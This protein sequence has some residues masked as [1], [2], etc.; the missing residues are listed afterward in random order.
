MWTADTWQEITII[1]NSLSMCA[2]SDLT[3]CTS[4]KD[5]TSTHR[6]PF[7]VYKTSEVGH[8][9]LWAQS[10]MGSAMGHDNLWVVQYPCIHNSC[11]W[12]VM[13]TR[14]YQGC[15]VF[16][17][18]PP[19]SYQHYE[20]MGGVSQR[21]VFMIKLDIQ[22]IKAWAALLDMGCSCYVSVEDKRFV[23]STLPRLY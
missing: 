9:Q 3:F 14:P 22:C 19:L 11:P 2:D 5:V 15:D 8:N 13:S 18:L 10:A 1:T 21:S 6:Y 4:H 17:F 12:N 23:A 20:F 16:N 7:K